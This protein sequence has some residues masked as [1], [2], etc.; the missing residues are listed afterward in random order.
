MK[1]LKS[2]LVLSAVAV[3]GLA[4]S[5]MADPMLPKPKRH[6]VVYVNHAPPAHEDLFPGAIVQPG[7]TDR[8]FSDTVNPPFGSLGPGIMQRSWWW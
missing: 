4:T 7:T 8:Y 5:G 1:L 2:G 3:L 6:K